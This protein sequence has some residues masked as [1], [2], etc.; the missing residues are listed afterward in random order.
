VIFSRCCLALAMLLLSSSLLRAAEEANQAAPAKE[1]ALESTPRFSI[2]IAALLSKSGCN[3]GAC[4]G[5]A[6]GKGGLKLSLRNQDALFDYK[7]LVEEHN[8]RRVD[9]FYPDRSLLLA[10]PLMSTAHEGGQRFT[11]DS[12]EAALLRRWIAGGAPFDPPETSRVKSIRVT[13]DDLILR[14]PEDRFQFK[15]TATF[16][17][18][19]EQ[20]VTRWACYDPV[21]PR[22][23]ITPEGA[24][25]FVRDGETTVLVRY[26]SAQKPVRVAL[27]PQRAE[28]F[29]NDAESANKIDEIVHT[30]L[31]ELQI[32]P[33]A[34][35]G[36]AEFLR[37][38]S[39]DL[40]G[41]LPTV[42][43][44][45][46]FIADKSD[47]NQH[48]KRA[49]LIDAWLLRPE[50]AELWALRWADLLREEEKYLD[51][52][53][54]RALHEWLRASFA[55]NR[56]LDQ[57]A[58]ALV[59]TIGSTYDNPPANYYRALRDPV[60][61]GEATAQV[62]LGTRL[63]CAKCHNHPFD[64]WTQ[65]D[66]H[67]WTAVF[68]R[69]DYDILENSRRDKNDKHEFIGEQRVKI[70][71]SGDVTNPRTN[72]PAE[73][74]LLGVKTPLDGKTPRL[75]ALADWLTAK[76]NK[77]FA[78]AMSN[79]LWHSL[80]GRGIVDPV[81][82]FRAS[83]PPSHPA[84]LDYLADELV[85]SGYDQR[86][87]LRLILNSA[88]YQRSSATNP[89]NVDDEQHYARAI[90]RKLSAE[91]LLDTLCQV[92]GSQ[93]D[94]ASLPDGSRSAQRAGLGARRR[95]EASSDVDKFLR[96]FG[97]PPRLT[98]CDCERSTAGTISQSFQML[99]GPL[100][101]ELLAQPDNQLDRWA[102]SQLPSAHLIEEIWW[103]TL[104]RAP[105]SEE[106]QAATQLLT[107]DK[108]RE[109]GD[110]RAVLED[111]V[112]ALVNSHEF[113]LRR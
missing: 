64:R 57:F 42:E 60:M 9:T 33:S 113:Q 23:T 92:T 111:L 56:P 8:G 52:K 25:T 29:W 5:N 99:S 82:D 2:E 104:T 68:A 62:F 53:G 109:S 83:N 72:K 10:K 40:L 93:L 45:K 73:P 80:L 105:T 38:L 24:A 37:R 70:L 94:W 46:A 58:R 89:T 67:Q 26:L 54:V 78:R 55:D 39:L 101:A 4:H 71:T 87:V 20:D 76:D 11:V 48:S 15:V 61:R 102:K 35:A 66:Y 79:R 63:Q 6:T 1:A 27:V 44:A 96:S 36:D 30:R 50:Y 88:T 97:K 34:A 65:D 13:P 106:Q 28:F 81:D 16:S 43:E 103:T 21:E 14:A 41:V 18:G 86:H 74:R 3:A 59:S 84:L 110:R 90:P 49:K 17:D 98:N 75:D 22:V 12:P 31:R 112:W 108:V 95:K 77:Q 51:I 85:K 7:A 91:I 19:T 32:N 100:P 47:E 69:I 107:S